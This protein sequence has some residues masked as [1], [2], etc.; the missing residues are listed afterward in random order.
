MRHSWVF[1]MATVATFAFSANAQDSYASEA[2]GIDAPTLSET[3]K[4][5][6]D[7]YRQYT[8]IAPPS[9]VEHNRALQSAPSDDFSLN[10][11]D[12]G[13][14]RFSIDLTTRP[15]DSPLPREQMSA[16]ATFQITP[17][18]SVGGELNLGGEELE[19]SSLWNNEDVETGV[20]FR[21]AFRF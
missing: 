21:S 14:W 4:A 15:D 1:C 8:I 9:T 11:A 12:A 5:E 17:R 7:W 2:L 19:D 3:E 6:P 20:R 16:G 10:W 18:F 13:R